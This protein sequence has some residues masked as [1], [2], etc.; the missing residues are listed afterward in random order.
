MFEKHKL[1]FSFLLTTRIIQAEKPNNT[2]PTAEVDFFVKGDISLD[3]C[4]L[5]N[6]HNWITTNGWK[7]LVKLSA[8][9]KAESVN[10]ADPALFIGTRKRDEEKLAGE[11]VK[12]A[13]I[14]SDIFAD[15]INDVTNNDKE[16]KA[17]WDSERPE[18][19]PLPGKIGENP[20]ITDLQ[21][22]CI[23]RCLRPDRVYIAVSIFISD[24]LGERYITPPVLNYD[25]IYNSSTRST[26]IVFIITP[27]SDPLNEIIKL[28]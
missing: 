9:L 12:H 7:D 15:L 2:L 28:A 19:L 13:T 1:M 27:G 26:P 25:Y 11:D 3:E 17:F 5:P 20:F 14:T 16:W 18:L 10:Q 23:L 22:L 8:I 6:P 24:V 21:K 4:A